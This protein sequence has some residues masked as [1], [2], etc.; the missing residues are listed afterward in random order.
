MVEKITILSVLEPFLNRPYEDI[1]LAD[2]SREINQP[3]STIRQHLNYLEKKGILKKKT[4]GRLTLYSLNTESPLTLHYLS[5]AEKNRLINLAEK[6]LILK[7]FISY[8]GSNLD[9]DNIAIIFGS[10][11]QDA[12][13]ANDIDII[14]TGKI[15]SKKDIDKLGEKLNRKIHLINVSDLEKITPTLRNEVIKKHIIIKGTEEVLRWMIMRR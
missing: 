1:H 12:E 9:E 10:A 2:I 3:Y 5:I 15:K 6:S 13:E 11:A 14:V 7:E 4:K 8:T